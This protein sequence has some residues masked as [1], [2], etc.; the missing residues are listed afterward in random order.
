MINY[1]LSRNKNF[2]GFLNPVRGSLLA[3][4]LL[5][6]TGLVLTVN[7]ADEDISVQEIVDNTNRTAYYQ[8][9]DGRAQV[10]MTITDSQGRERMRR[11]TILRRDQRPPEDKADQISPENFMGNQKYYVYFQEP[12]DWRESV[13]LVH[14]KIERGVDDDRWLYLPGLDVVKR[15]SATDKRNSFV[16]SHFFYEDVS[17]RNPA[18]DKQELINT[19]DTYYV[20]KNTPKKPEMVEFDHYRMWIHK[21]TFVP[22]QTIYYD[23]EGEAYRKYS[24]LGVEKIQGYRTV[25]KA[26]MED[27]RNGGHTTLEYE[28]VEYNLDIPEDIFSER[29]LRRP[30]Q[31]YLQ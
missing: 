6:A 21:N 17:G 10:T 1:K 24:V 5:F 8:G 19:T 31:E 13:F 25:T 3:G 9:K 23:S 22:V 7:A 16:G 27:L 18:A 15:I 12:A 11:F 2:P 26:R 14:K 28:N 4:V 29:Y 20:L 30:P